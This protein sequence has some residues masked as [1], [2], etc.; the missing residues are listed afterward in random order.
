M[1]LRFRPHGLSLDCSSS[2]C[3]GFFT[4]GTALVVQISPNALVG[5]ITGLH[6]SWVGVMGSAV[7]PTLVALLADHAFGGT[8]QA[9]GEALSRASTM[10]CVT[11]SF[12]LLAVAWRLRRF[13][14]E[15]AAPLRTKAARM[16]AR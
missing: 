4:I 13:A 2:A 5:K 3:P 8:R 1:H 10:F 15:E 12:C 9:L 16:D 11:G 14:G 6:F 7:A